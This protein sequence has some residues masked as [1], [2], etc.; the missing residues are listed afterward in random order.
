[1]GILP[2]DT[3]S[4]GLKGATLSVAVIG[5][6]IGGLCLAIGLLKHH[7]IDV[8][9]Y[10]AAPSFGEIGAGVAI[11]PNA[12]RALQL[13]GPELGEAFNKQATPNLWKSHQNFFAQCR[14]GKGEHEGEIIAEQS[15]AGGMQSVHRAHFLD[16]LVKLVPKQCA[17]FG[18][19]LVAIDDKTSS[20][21]RVILHFKDGTDTTVDAAIGAD[22]VHSAVRQYLL[23]EMH[24]AVKPVFSGSFSYRGIVKM[25]HAIEKL[26][27]ES[28]QNCVMV[29]GPGA[30]VLSYPIEHGE[31][32]NIVIVDLEVE[33]WEH[34]KWIVPAKRE[35][36]ERLLEGWGK[37]AQAMIELLDTPDLAAWSLWDHPPAP[38]YHKGAVA[39][40]GD[41]AHAATPF[42]G[43]GAGQ[44]IEDAL[45]LE[46]LLGKV[47]TTDQIP[48]AFAAYDQVR[49]PRSQRNVTTSREAGLLVGMKQEGVGSD[50]RKMKERLDVRMHWIWNRSMEAQNAE[51]VRLF[52]E[53]L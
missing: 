7:H 31:L 14:V 46:T 51:A 5:G 44:A 48:H 10:E 40:M 35:S 49:R 15:T 4:V 19:R 27:A 8:Q 52:E 39:M 12:Q 17:H 25:E 53:S 13:I 38:F 23:G 1:M 3:S 9:I 18:K 37:H 42:Q 28:A 22:G 50:L 34:E 2:N 24:P 36:M 29:C 6:G 45:V 21:G 11:G 41:A 26:G 47:Q 43:Q 33:K 16:A 20:G 30:A 32:L